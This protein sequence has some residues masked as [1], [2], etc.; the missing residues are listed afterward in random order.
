MAES[1][2]LP[3]LAVGRAGDAVTLASFSSCENEDERK[4]IE[5]IFTKLLVA[6][7][8]KLKSEERTRLAWNGG[9]VCCQMDRQGQL[10]YC[11]VTSSISYPE[12]LAY[13]LLADFMLLV[14]SCGTDPTLLG[15]GGLTQVLKPQMQDLLESYDKMG[16]RQSAIIKAQQAVAIVTSTMKD[17]YSV[18]MAN[19]GD[20][21]DLESK[22]SAAADAAVRFNNQAAVLNA[23]YRRRN[24]RNMMLLVGTISVLVI[25]L[26]FVLYRRASSRHAIDTDQ[27]A[28]QTT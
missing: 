25:I 15:E 12:P 2:E 13:K 1:K 26:V 10:L 24:Q 18:Q 19:M 9:S 3:Y 27:P 16:H 5:G 7:K 11:V 17:N 21:Q 6:A 28:G 4:Q 23:H 14:S 20:A 8:K 22:T